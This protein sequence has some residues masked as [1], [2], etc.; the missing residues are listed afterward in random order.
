MVC[1]YVGGHTP[2][3]TY[4]RVSDYTEGVTVLFDPKITSYSECLDHF[5]DAH[6]PFRCNRA[7]TQCGLRSDC[8]VV[9][10]RQG[11]THVECGGMTK[12]RKPTS[13]RKYDNWRKTA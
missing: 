10:S 2:Y 11:S 3:P 9:G 7:S 5:F 1:V 8:A 4:E 13:R 6:T 12:S